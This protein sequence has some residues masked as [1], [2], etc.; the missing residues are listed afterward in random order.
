MRSSTEGDEAL[1]C[2]VG[3]LAMIRLSKQ[4]FALDLKTL[5]QSM[6]QLIKG[7]AQR[8]NKPRRS[9]AGRVTGGV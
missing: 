8:T 7:K 3:N 5:A 9:R 6:Q 2:L 4:M 1:D